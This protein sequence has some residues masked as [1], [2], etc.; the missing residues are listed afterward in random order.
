[1]SSIILLYPRNKTSIYFFS[2]DHRHKYLNSE[3]ALRWDAL[4]WHDFG[5]SEI[6]RQVFISYEVVS[7]KDQ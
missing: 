2:E 3:K 1:M 5:L 6:E 7:H 4:C